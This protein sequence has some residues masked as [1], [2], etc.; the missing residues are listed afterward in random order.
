MP[1]GGSGCWHRTSANQLAIFRRKQ[2]VRADE[3]DFRARTKYI[4]DYADAVLVCVNL[5]HRCSVKAHRKGVTGWNN[6]ERQQKQLGNDFR[7]R[8]SPF[9]IGGTCDRFPPLVAPC[10]V[11]TLF[12]WVCHLAPYNSTLRKG[13]SLKL[14]LASTTEQLLRILKHSLIESIDDCSIDSILNHS[15][16]VYEE[17]L[18]SII[19]RFVPHDATFTLVICETDDP[20]PFDRSW[21]DQG[22]FDLAD[23]LQDSQ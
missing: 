8:C 6:I 14:C 9:S 13:R 10:A 20:G 17:G 23:S 3:M 1:N 21:H 19:E 5:G 4:G 7:P 22:E 15:Q 16:S 18:H 12:K 11:E 2:G